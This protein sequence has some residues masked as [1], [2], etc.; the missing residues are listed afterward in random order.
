MD[1]EDIRRAVDRARQFTDTVADSRVA[2]TL[3]V[4]TPH[5]AEVAAVRHLHTPE[6]RRNGAALVQTQRELLEQALVGWSGLRP[7]DLLPPEALEDLT[8]EQRG[9]PLAYSAALV[10]L[11]LD[12]QPAWASQWWGRLLVRI[13][14]RNRA[15]DTAAKN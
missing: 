12:A 1:I 4:P 10:P 2:V 9:E 14:A 11:L 3:R 13:E 6:G 5:E 7:A 15:R 8:P